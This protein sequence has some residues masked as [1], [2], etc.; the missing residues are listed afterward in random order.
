MNTTF[1]H[2]IPRR[3]LA[4]ALFAVAS[5]AF[6]WSSA[7]HAADAPTVIRIGSP[8]LGTAGKPSASAGPLT[9]VQWHKWLEQEF[10]KDG[11]KVEWN[12]FR[13]AG[14]AIAEGLAAK[15][16]DVVFLGDLASVIGRARGLPT[17]YIFASGR[18][19]NSYLATAPGVDIKT[20]ADLK[21]KKISVLKG[22]A[23]QRPFDNLLASAGLTEKDVKVI[24][25]DWPSSKTAVVAKEVDATF[26]NSDLYA[27]RD[28]GVNVP[29]TTKGRGPEF[30]IDAGVLATEDF[31]AKY[32]EVTARLVKQLVRAAHFA[33]QES[34]REAFIKLS[35]EHSGNPELG[36]RSEFDGEN[37]KERFSPLIDEDLV[38][39]YQRVVD[40]GVKLGLIKQGF[41][42]KEWFVPQFVQ[43][44]VKDLKLEKF[45]TELDAQGK[46]I[47][48]KTK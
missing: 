32:P 19:T 31:I 2:R 29:L 9:V 24:N 5:A 47:K 25:L 41:A 18:G 16:L 15:Q 40:E 46:A 11:I 37:L 3:V 33:S 20:V 7:S 27:L 10:A 39:D 12:F 14:P 34:N 8:D 44:A 28:K 36:I 6:F 21:G 17:K 48:P 45:W 43:Q 22:T 35:V 30:K 26:G 42:V 1:I 4:S 13:G 23:Y 38:A